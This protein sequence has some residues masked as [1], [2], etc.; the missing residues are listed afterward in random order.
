[1]SDAFKALRRLTRVSFR[2]LHRGKTDDHKIYKVKS[3]TWTPSP[4]GTNAKTVTFDW[5]DHQTGQTKTTSVFDYFLQR[6]NIR[7]TSWQLPL[8]ETSRGGYFPWEVCHLDRFNRYPFKLDPDQTA[9]MIK[10]A[11]QRPPQRKSDIMAAVKSLNWGG[12]RYLRDLKITIDPQMSLTQAR[13]LKNPE[14]S[15]S[16]GKINPGVTGRWDL[17]GKKFVTPNSTPLKSWAFVVTESCIDKPGLDN[18]IKVF[19]QVYQGHGGRL[20]RPPQVYSFPRGK[21]LG[22][23]TREAYFA[24]GKNAQATPQII[25][26][27]LREKTAFTYQRMK[28]NS[29]CRWACLTQMLNV[30]HVRKAQPQYCSNVCM[31]VNS[32]LGGQ[33]SRIPGVGSA[34]AFFKVPTMMIGV[35][36]SHGAAGTEMASMAAM[37]VSMD[38][39]AATYCAAV[40]TN[41][42]R[43]EILTPENVIGMLGDLVKTWRTRNGTDP[44]H[45]YYFR[46]GVAEGQ[47]SH[48][49][50]L[51]VEN[52]KECFRQ[53]T[54]K[55]PKIT[56]V[57][58][59]KRHHVRF[60]PEKGDKNGNPLPGT[61]VEREVTHPFH[62]DFYLCSHVA[63]QGTARPVH[64]HVIH[65]EIKPSSDDL[66]KMIYQQCYQYA[67]STTPVSL[68]PAVYYAHLASARA[69]AH[70]NMP[71]SDQAPPEKRHLVMPSPGLGAKWDPSEGAGTPTQRQVQGEALP[72]LPLGGPDARPDAI[73][74]FR[75]TMWFI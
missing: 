56:A 49:M 34:S 2:I 54:G 65:D 16:N 36:V 64:Y 19:S 70:E 38:K 57:V 10:F 69:R 18:F 9:S 14:I 32:K 33:T 41:G 62:Y 46:D 17:R 11:V 21:D 68:H 71:T 31:K 12:D 8:I 47:F 74:I 45:V 58:A 35:D 30:N 48:V 1:M 43:R 55:V 53:V 61:L 66:Q 73:Q 29:D 75:N 3:Y 72:V 6:Y 39:D 37:S 26:Y 52:V 5:K 13:L 7:L 63:I 27:I 4:Q 42:T 59:T 50:D 25:F 51:E 60:F 28:K 40:Q 44:Q 20:E 15:Y 22:D 67:R 24:T 23:L